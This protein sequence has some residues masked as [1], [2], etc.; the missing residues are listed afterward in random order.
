MVSVSNLKSAREDYFLAFTESSE[1]DIIKFSRSVSSHSEVAP[2]W[3]TA[4]GRRRG[5]NEFHGPCQ[6]T[7]GDMVELEHF[8]SRKQSQPATGAIES[9]PIEKRPKCCLDCGPPS[10][11]EI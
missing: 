6:F 5:F 11:L 2:P 9:S 7:S 4:D 3:K 10:V 1:K 8:G